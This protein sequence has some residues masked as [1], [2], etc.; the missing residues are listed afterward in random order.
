VDEADWGACRK[1]YWTDRRF[2]NEVIESVN[3]AISALKLRLGASKLVLVGY[4]GGG[5]V[6]ALVAARR[7]DVA[8]LV[9]VAGNLDHR[10]WTSLH[11]DTPLDNSLNAADEWRKLQSVPQKH[12]IGERDEVIS[13]DVSRSY[14]GRFPVNH[15][16]ELITMP[17]FGHSCCWVDKWPEIW[18][19]QLK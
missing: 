3:Q 4:S 7:N 5:A 19:E 17:G 6:A 16:P 13:A 11:H 14:A 12:L 1:T 15:R 2:S 8:Q 10:A 18:T 9:T